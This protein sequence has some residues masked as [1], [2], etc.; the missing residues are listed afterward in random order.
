MVIFKISHYLLKYCQHSYIISRFKI[1][2]QVMTTN[3]KF[4]NLIYK[5]CPHY[6]KRLATLKCLRGP[7]YYIGIP[8]TIYIL[9]K[10]NKKL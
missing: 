1:T 2:A 7:L 5:N 8:N 4:V 6:K 3:L 10:L 9:K